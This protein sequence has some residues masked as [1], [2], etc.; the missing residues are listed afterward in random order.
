MGTLFGGPCTKDPII[1]GLFWG[2]L[3]LGNYHLGRLASKLHAVSLE[4][5]GWRFVGLGFRDGGYIGMMEKKMETIAGF[6]G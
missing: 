3:I 4:C 2:P 5:L 6:L 1:W